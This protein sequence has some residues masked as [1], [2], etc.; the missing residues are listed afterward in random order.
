MKYP[1]VSIV[2][3]DVSVR[4]AMALL[5]QSAGM[6]SQ[7][8]GSAEQF[9]SE[10]IACQDDIMVLDLNLPG[11]SGL[12]LLKK[13]R[14]DGMNIQVIV[15]TAFDDPLSRE[16]CKSYGVLVYLRKP[17]DGAALIDLIRYN[18]PMAILDKNQTHKI[19]IS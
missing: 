14:L 5:L 16:L 1:V 10:F 12:D 19:K 2:E 9:L 8:F 3:D 4:E 15:T 17:V 6:D 13:I 7:S 11:M 18:L